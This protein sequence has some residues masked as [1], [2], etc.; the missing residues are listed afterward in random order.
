MRSRAGDVR[1]HPALS[2]DRAAAATVPSCRTMQDLHPVARASS[3][4]P[5]EEPR[6]GRSASPCDAARRMLA[7]RQPTGGGHHAERWHRR[8]DRECNEPASRGCVARAPCAGSAR[9]RE[10][11][12][13]AGLRRGAGRA[14][15]QLRRARRDWRRRRCVLARR[16]GRRPL[17]WPAHAR[18]RRAVGR[19]HDGR[20]HVGPEGPLGD[21]AGAR[22]RAQPPAQW[23]PRTRRRAT[24][25]PS[26]KSPSPRRTPSARPR[27]S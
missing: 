17:G 25:V 6:K 13:R 21:A 1:Q 3:L 14:G 10:R 26:R 27:E 9:A 23:L 15:A 20:R 7:R 24:C 18:G 11:V 8:P 16:E 2:D 19:G 5:R 12:R 22:E 4:P